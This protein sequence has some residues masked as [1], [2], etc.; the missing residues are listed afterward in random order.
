MLWPL[1]ISLPSSF[2]TLLSSLIPLS[3]PLSLRVTAHWKTNILTLCTPPS[4][5]PHS[6]INYPS[7]HSSP[8]Y[9]S[10]SLAC[11]HI[12]PAAYPLRIIHQRQPFRPALGEQGKTQHNIKLVRERERVVWCEKEVSWREGMCG[13]SSMA[14]MLS[15]AWE[16]L[17]QYIPVWAAVLF[18]IDCLQKFRN[19]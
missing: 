10:Y 4:N 7:L 12:L 18:F 14:P 17:I 5:P 19:E 3:A 9:L 13:I 8:L 6:S 15:G 11:N 1:L 2:L 16:S